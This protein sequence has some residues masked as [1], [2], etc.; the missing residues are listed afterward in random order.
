[1]PKKFKLFVAT[2]AHGTLRRVDKASKILDEYLKSQV[3]GWNDEMW[4]LNEGYIKECEEN[5]RPIMASRLIAPTSMVTE[6]VWG[7]LLGTLKPYI[8][9]GARSFKVL[10]DYSNIRGLMDLVVLERKPKEVKSETTEI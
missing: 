10:A 9:K 3:T 4:K 6:E 5:K 7:M 2:N 1:M 8:P